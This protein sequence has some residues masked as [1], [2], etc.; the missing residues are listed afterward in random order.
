MAANDNAAQQSS[1]SGCYGELEKRTYSVQEIAKIL[2]I[3]RSKAYQLCDGKAFKVVKL[4]R[5]VRISKISFDEW[6]ERNL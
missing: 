5:L 6:L 4:G 3:S 2:Q 1:F